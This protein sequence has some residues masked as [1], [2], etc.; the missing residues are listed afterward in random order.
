MQETSKLEDIPVPVKLK[1][2]GLWTSLMFCYIYGDYFGLF[3]AGNLQDMLQ[4]KM[5]P[6]GPATQGVLLGT[7]ILLAV[8][9]LMIFLSL[10]LKSAI[11]RWVN[12][13]LG[14]F[15]ALVMLV[16]MP[17]SWW[18]YLFFGVIEIVLSLLIVWH[19]WKWP[20]ASN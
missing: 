2:A 10:A 15:Y 12:I 9:A 20:R 4:G 6:L 5:G 19:A 16:S 14:V 1:L 17:G 8:P 11:N 7:S 3:Q 13:V 18:F